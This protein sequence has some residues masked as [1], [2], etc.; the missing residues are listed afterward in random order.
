MLSCIAL[1]SLARDNGGLGWTELQ[2]IFEVYVMTYLYFGRPTGNT[3]I[4][5]NA[6][7]YTRK[8]LSKFILLLN[9]S[10]TPHLDLE[11]YRLVEPQLT[12]RITP[13]A[14]AV[15]LRAESH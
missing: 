12:P 9:K 15:A 6:W 14:R 7:F 4:Y 5:F 11:K 1:S 10:G 2:N 13:V 3:Y 8:Y